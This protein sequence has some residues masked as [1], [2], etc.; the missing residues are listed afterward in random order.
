MASIK[1]PIPAFN[2][3]VNVEGIDLECSE[4][5]GLKATREFH[6]VR[7][8]THNNYHFRI[9]TRMT[10]GDI[11]LKKGVIT[12]KSKSLFKTLKSKSD[13]NS[14]NPIEN[15]FQDITIQLLDETKTA[16]CTWTLINP[17]MVSWEFSPLN[18]MSNEIM[19]ET[20]VFNC[21]EIKMNFS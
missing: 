17:F 21:I 14:R 1:F 6:E 7:S 20:I 13:W 4:V 5:S 3:K 19:F 16:K 8:G 18:A 2:F 11:T 15:Q 12:A 10:Y 9:P